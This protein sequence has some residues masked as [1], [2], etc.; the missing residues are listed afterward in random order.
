MDPG[1]YTP[2]SI[3]SLFVLPALIIAAAI[4]FAILLKEKG[5]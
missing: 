4:L 5:E 1:P 2:G 3:F